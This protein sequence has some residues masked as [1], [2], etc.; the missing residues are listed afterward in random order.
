MKTNPLTKPSMTVGQLAKLGDEDRV[1]VIAK[2][3]LES[4]MRLAH[5]ASIGVDIELDK[6]RRFN[7]I[8]DQLTK[9]TL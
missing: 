9:V 3:P 4:R 5:L 1:A 6:I 8:I 7:T 2:L